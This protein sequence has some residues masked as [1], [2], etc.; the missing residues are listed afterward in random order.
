MG[1]YFYDGF[2]AKYIY[3]PHPT[4]GQYEKY[5]VG[6]EIDG[7]YFALT[8]H[9]L[10]TEDNLVQVKIIAHDIAGTDAECKAYRKRREDYANHLAE[11]DILE[12]AEEDANMGWHYE[13]QLT[14]H[15]KKLYTTADRQN[16]TQKRNSLITDEW[17]AGGITK[18]ALGRKYGLSDSRITLIIWSELRHRQYEEVRNRRKQKSSIR[19]PDFPNSEYYDMVHEW[20]AEQQYQEIQEFI[21]E[22]I[23]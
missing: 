20:D 3:A 17:L 19:D 15:W 9:I 8:E 7:A 10:Y 14:K 21:H 18:A 5:I 11:T 23:K 22:K 12:A 2:N 6:A 13:D 4:T 16:Y 1:K